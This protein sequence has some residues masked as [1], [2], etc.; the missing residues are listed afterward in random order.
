MYSIAVHS[1]PS[2]NI[3]RRY[4]EFKGT[5]KMGYVSPRFLFQG[6][7]SYADRYT[8]ICK[9]AIYG[10][11]VSGCSNDLRNFRGVDFG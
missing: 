2:L 9:W 11:Y 1:T 3:I 5:P 6:I 8:G 10:T 4:H 7:R